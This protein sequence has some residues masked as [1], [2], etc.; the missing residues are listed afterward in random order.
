MLRLAELAAV[1]AVRP[2]LLLLDEPSSGV[3]QKETEA[4]AP[5]LR[6]LA[7]YLDATVLLIEHDMPL[8]MGL[9]DRIVAMAAGKVV[10]IGVA[11]RGAGPPRGA[12]LVPGSDRVSPLLDDAGIDLHYGRVQVLFDLS[13]AVEE[14]RDGGAARHERC[15]EVDVPQGGVEP[16]GGQPGL[17]GVRRRG[18]HRR[19]RRTRSRRGDWPTC[20][21]GEA[22]SPTSPSRRTCASAGTSCDGAGRRRSWRPGWTGPS[23][24]SRGWGSV[25]SS[26]PA[27]SRAASSRCWPSPGPWCCS[28][29]C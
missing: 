16:V 19:C 22:C 24:S 7:E 18:H 10:T 25:A 1:V 11:G 5:L 14:R 6:R 26:W 4:L 28:R 12:A 3:A 20:P 8:V 21:A 15:R 9:S 27:R 2:K 23:G 29:G 17:R 13:I